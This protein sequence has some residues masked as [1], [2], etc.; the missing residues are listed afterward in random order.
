MNVFF[1]LQFNVWDYAL[2]MDEI[3]R[4]S[5]S[6]GNAGNVIP[7]YTIREAIYGDVIVSDNGEMCQ[8]KY[9]SDTTSLMCL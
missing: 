8:C 4:I 6:C 3:K 7:W 1:V 9:S 2:T 5:S